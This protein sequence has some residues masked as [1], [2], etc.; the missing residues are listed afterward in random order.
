[1]AIPEQVARQSE[2]AE[3]RQ[4]EL[5]VPQSPGETPPSGE[6]PGGEQPPGETPPSGGQPGSA[7]D[8]HAELEKANQRYRS[9]Q[10]MYEAERRRAGEQ[11]ERMTE[12]I[13]KLLA[14]QTAKPVEPAA[15]PAH[16]PDDVETF[17]AET[18]DFVT[19]V[20][21]NVA[22]SVATQVV[23][24]MLAQKLTPITQTVNAVTE[25]VQKSAADEYYEALS[26]TVPDW[27]TINVDP[28][29]MQWLAQ[30]DPFSGMPRQALLAD[31]HQRLEHPRVAA[32]FNA[33]KSATGRPAATPAA[34]AA[35]SQQRRPPA[36]E[37]ATLV[38]PNRS[39]SGVRPGGQTQGRTYTRAE[40]SKFYRDVREG[41]LDADTA[42]V[43]ERDI[44][45][46]QS[47]GRI[48]G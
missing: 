14:A 46:A 39:S 10:G 38:E 31:A 13:D 12:Q 23:E 7:P 15:Q 2:A 18:I 4:Q 27:Q 25:R 20:S 44:L 16:A 11:I 21:T 9:L 48:V 36:D 43:V 5:L 1:M 33:W 34:P 35:A 30:P 6:P 41:R 26:A 47:Q 45:L 3:R 28:E 32:M 8:L 24:Q 37:R 29:F 17:G 42:T 40:V 19:R 22:R